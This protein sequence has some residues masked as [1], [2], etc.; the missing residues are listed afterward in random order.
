M[1]LNPTRQNRGQTPVVQSESWTKIGNM[2]SAAVGLP[3]EQLNSSLTLILASATRVFFS[4]EQESLEADIKTGMSYL[5]QCLGAVGSA[6]YITPR[7]GYNRSDQLYCVSEDFSGYLN[8]EITPYFHSFSGIT[9]AGYIPHTG[10][11]TDQKK[12]R[13]I[14]SGEKLL[15]LPLLVGDEGEVPSGYLALTFLQDTPD[16]TPQQMILL[17]GFA[18]LAFLTVDRVVTVSGFFE[19]ENMLLLAEKTV[20]I[21]FFHNDVINNHITFTPQ[22]K[23]IFELDEDN[24]LV[25]MNFYINRIHPDDQKAVVDSFRSSIVNGRSSEVT[26]RLNLPSGNRKIVRSKANVSFNKEGDVV[27]RYG[28]VQDITGSYEQE[29]RLRL[30]MAV[31]ESIREA[32]V[33]TDK[34]FRIEAVN[35]AYSAITGYS[36]EELKGEVTSFLSHESRI[37]A[38]AE[39]IMQSLKKQGYWFG[40]ITDQKKNGESFA[41]RMIITVVRDEHDEVSHYIATFTDESQ[42]KKSEEQLKLLTNYDPLTSLPNRDFILRNLGETLA[43]MKEKKQMMGLITIDLDNFKHINDSLGHPAGDRL[44]QE[45]SQRLKGRLRKTD[46]LAR[47]G[48][49]EFVVVLKNIASRE[50]IATVAESIL[51]LMKAPFDLGIGKQLRVGAS[52]GI[53]IFP[54]QGSDV[55]ELL[56]QADAALYEAKRNGRNHYSFYSN[57]MTRLVSERLELE[58]DLR[59]ALHNSDELEL[60]YQPQ[61]SG[62]DGGIIGVEA[63][64][65]WNHPEQGLISPGVFLPIAEDSGLMPE[66]DFWVIETACRQIAQWQQARVAPFTV[67]INISQPTFANTDVLEMVS[68][69]I[70]ELNI[71]PSWLELEITEGA[72]LEPSEDVLRMIDG[73]KTLGVKLAIDDFGTG[74]SCLAYLHRY[75]VDKLKID[76]SFVVAMDSEEECRVIVKTIINMAHGLGLEVLAEGVEE[77]HQ[78]DFLLNNGCHMYQGYFFSRPVPVKELSPM[79]KPEDAAVL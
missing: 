52:M 57:E 19:R 15:L 70:R 64:I 2:A 66:L 33:I 75:H 6:L 32:A 69:L 44:L 42:L 39:G 27:A 53:S 77:E 18:Q 56:R 58:N 68:R 40:E 1:V 10:E 16:V 50:H 17:T 55:N 62:R 65:R 4:T 9:R 48:G 63:L 79:I 34:D 38:S 21:G 73:L 11:T 3:P 13:T 78:L 5:M 23:T 37:P 76:R 31:F 71:D 61:A 46:I 26:Y 20:N 30:S 41:K 74:Y 45:F 14:L 28:T 25:D 49:D 51:E 12:L 22:T 54:E 36:E 8:S 59:I 24:E 60:F 7:P 35:P 47:L 29:R 43:E 72:L 67:A